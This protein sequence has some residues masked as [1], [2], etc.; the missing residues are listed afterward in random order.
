[1]HGV[2]LHIYNAERCATGRSI[3]TRH[4]RRLACKSR[5]AQRWRLG[6]GVLDVIRAA[7]AKLGPEQAKEVFIRSLLHEILSILVR[8]CSGRSMVLTR[9]VS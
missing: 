2:N 3:F 1:M 8:M 5:N 9:A 4:R 6:L 7:L